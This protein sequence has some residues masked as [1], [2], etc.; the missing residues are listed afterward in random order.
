MKSRKTESTKTEVVDD[1]PSWS[2]AEGQTTTVEATYHS[3][4]KGSLPKASKTPQGV[5]SRDTRKNREDDQ[6]K[7]F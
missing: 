4:E 3:S 7:F 5:K 1:T 6:K 2:A